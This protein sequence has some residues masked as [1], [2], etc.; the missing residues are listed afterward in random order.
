M[1][2]I[3]K[4]A[5]SLWLAGALCLVGSSSFSRNQYGDP[6]APVAGKVLGMVIHTSVPEELRSV[7]VEALTDQY[8]KD[9]GISVTQDEIEAYRDQMA[10]V[11][12]EDRQSQVKRREEVARALKSDNLL[13]TERQSL[14][15]ELSQIDELLANLAEMDMD[16][17]KEEDKTAR[18]EAAAAFILQWKINRALYQQYGGRI[19]FQQGGPEPLDAYRAFLEERHRAG[20]FEISNLELADAFWR[21]YR[22]DALHSFYP[23]GSIEEVQA[24]KTPSW[25]ADSAD[26]AVPQDSGSASIDGGAPMTNP[27]PTKPEALAN[28]EAAYGGPSQTGF[29]SAVFSDRVLDTDTLEQKALERYRYFVGD[30]WGRFG[31]A[32]WMAPWREVY[33]RADA[34]KR[35]I[36]AE[37]RGIQDPDAARSVPMILEAIED[38]EKARAALAAAYDDPAVTEL[39]VFNLGDGG[40]MSGLLIAGR[41]PGAGDAI[42]LVFLMD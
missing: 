25:L 29:G 42:L 30:L 38:A 5:T 8:A 32:A 35:D 36:V 22:T 27:D 21:Y 31:E 18:E 37:L 20:D 13:E 16:A 11:M 7:I 3:V 34:G 33:E 19:L 14:A 39:R 2:S 1:A 4:K 12:A 9:K 40:A 28:L 17:G 15:A 6:T 41:R 23:P 10:R 24:F 26:P